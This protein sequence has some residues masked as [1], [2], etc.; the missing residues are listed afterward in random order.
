MNVYSL[1]MADTIEQRGDG[2]LQQ[3]GMLL[4][5][6]IPIALKDNIHTLDMPTTVVV[7]RGLASGLIEVRDRA[8]GERVELNAEGA[9]DELIGLLRP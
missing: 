2:L 3:K 9:A 1:W 8:S 7:D 6:G 4:E 5:D